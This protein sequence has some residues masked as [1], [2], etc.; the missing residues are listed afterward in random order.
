MSTNDYHSHNP[1]FCD[2]LTTLFDLLGLYDSSYI[3]ECI[4]IELLT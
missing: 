4:A 3:E 1:I 2:S